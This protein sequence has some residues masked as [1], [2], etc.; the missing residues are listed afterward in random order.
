MYISGGV[1]ENEVDNLLAMCI[2][3][4]YLGKPPTKTLNVHSNQLLVSR[5]LN[6]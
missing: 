3:K 5:L 2:S 4:K 1:F 6:K